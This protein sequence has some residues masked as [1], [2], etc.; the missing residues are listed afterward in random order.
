M[1]QKII[2]N[3]EFLST[4]FPP[5]WEDKARQL[6]ALTRM[7]NLKSP[8]DLLRLLLIHL[9]DG[10]SMREASARAKQGGLPHI[11][12]VA[13]FKRLRSSSEWLR[14]MCLELLKRRGLF[15]NPPDW[16]SD[17]NV[18][19]VDA[20]NVSE[21]G[22]TGTDWRLHYSIMLFG[23]QCDQFIVSRQDLGE[24]FTNFKVDEGDLYIGDRAYGRLKGLKYVKDNGGH[25][26]AR[27]KNKSFKIFDNDR[28]EINLLDILKGI[29]IGEPIDLQIFANV[30]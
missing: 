6:K 17:Y 30:G 26:L 7:R 14:W 20:S 2:D 21:P 10:C 16:L 24:S 8:G 1:E 5:D 19:S 3:W 4:F 13:L 29:N 28:K 22:S 12:A 11:S 15:C 9:G 18:K 27:L 25:F 23:L